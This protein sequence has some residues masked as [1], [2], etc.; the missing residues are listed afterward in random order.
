MAKRAA[1]HRAGIISH[2]LPIALAICRSAQSQYER[3]RAG[4]SVAASIAFATSAKEGSS[5]TRSLIGVAS[6]APFW[7]T[8]VARNVIGVFLEDVNSILG[9]Y[10]AIEF[11]NTIGTS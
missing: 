3:M 4:R 11:P 10:T 2:G 9:T 1:V 8:T 7:M 5:R 6:S